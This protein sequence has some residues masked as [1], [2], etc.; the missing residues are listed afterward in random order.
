MATVLQIPQ[1]SSV[2]SPLGA[3]V[4]HFNSSSKSVQNAF[5]KLLNDS[6]SEKKR[7]KLKAKMTEKEYF[8]MLDHSIEQ[9]ENGNTIAME[10]GETLQQYMSR[11][12]CT[13]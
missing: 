12:S 5:A 8:D 11:L 7:A 2:M 9:A 1:N 6:M 10:E 13:K 3:L 4:A